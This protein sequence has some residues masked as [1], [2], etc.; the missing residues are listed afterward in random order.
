ME[1]VEGLAAEFR[2]G[3]AGCGD[4]P[5]LAWPRGAVRLGAEEGRIG[6]DHQAVGG[7]QP[8]RVANA[9]SVA[10]G[11]DAGEGGPGPEVK[12][13]AHIGGI[14]GEAVKD[15]AGGVERACAQ[16]VDEVVEGIAAVKYYGLVD[17]AGTRRVDAPEL[18]FEDGKLTAAFGGGVVIVESDLAPGDASRVGDDQAKVLPEV[19]GFVGVERVNTGGAPDVG[20]RLGKSEGLEAVVGGR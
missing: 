2:K 13:L 5:G 20:V 1:V 11:D 8:C 17:A 6:L 18:L 9:G 19:R 7:D 3:A 4:H 10:V 16:D 12:N 15:E 14:A